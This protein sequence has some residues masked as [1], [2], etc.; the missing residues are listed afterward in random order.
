MSIEAAT[1]NIWQK[2]GPWMERMP[3]LVLALRDLNA[4]VIG[5][6]EVRKEK[7][8]D[9]LAILAKECGYHHAYG[10]AFD[11]GFGL[12]GNGILSRYPIV[13]SEMI[14][15]PG[16]Q[17]EWRCLVFAEIDAP[18][19][20]VPFFTTHLNWRLD[21]GASRIEQ[22]LAIAN[23]IEARVTDAHFPAILTGD[24]NA[25]PDSDE[26]RFF[27]G[28][29]GIDGKYVY[30]ADAWVFAG[31][32]EDGAT[33]SKTNPFGVTH[34]EAERRIDYVMVRAPVQ[35]LGEPVRARVVC[36]KAIEGMFP[37]DHFGVS[38]TICT[39]QVG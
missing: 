20:R 5:L 7:E 17:M 26:M 36:N 37:T 35:S 23:A 2:F 16:K 8:F 12:T 32:R 19:G 22:V 14:P 28:L 29:T 10:A 13:R 18:F 27:R 1:L 25:E 31:G 15:L 39:E 38:A 34:R 33:Y 24:F 30:Y 21:D 6:Q 9:Q 4:D 3:R 11:D